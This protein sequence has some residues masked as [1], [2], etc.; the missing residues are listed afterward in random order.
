MINYKNDKQ[1]WIDRLNSFPLG[2]NL[3][4]RCL[5]NEINAQRFVRLQQILDRSI[6]QQLKQRI[7][8]S[9]IDHQLDFLHLFMQ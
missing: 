2:P 3:P 5:P 8:R 7:N 1:Y 9:S 4:L 6:W